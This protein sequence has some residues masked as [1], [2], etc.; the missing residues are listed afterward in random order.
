MN[1]LFEL[2]HPAHFH[3]FKN[4]INKLIVTGHKVIVL[5]KS[6]PPLPDLLK[7]QAEW[8]VIFEGKKGSKLFLKIVKQFYFT[9]LAIKIILKERIDYCVGVSFTMPHAAFLT[10]RRCLVLDDDDK[11]ATPVFTLLSHSLATRVLSPDCLQTDDLKYKYTYYQ[12]LHEL[13]YLHPEVF[14]P[15]KTVLKELNLSENEKIILVRFNAFTA[16]HDHGEKGLNDLQRKEL[17]SLLSKYG[18]VIIS[19]EASLHPD[20]AI[21]QEKISPDKI[22]DLMTFASLYVGESQTMAS[23]AAVLGIPAVR[24]NTFKNRISYLTELEEKY[25]LLFSFT[26]DEF[27]QALEKIKELLMPGTLQLWAAKRLKFLKSKI[28]VADFITAEIL[29]LNS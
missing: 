10:H 23:E 26:P 24:I 16:H 25:G 27:N 5:A 2:N 29:K 19:S 15:N 1:I 13:S 20:L 17:V 8:T 21:Y 7:T 3:L 22:H 14:K 12:G 6:N 18:R 9:L 28:N 4:P 11:A